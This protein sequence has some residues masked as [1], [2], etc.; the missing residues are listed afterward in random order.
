MFRKVRY[1]TVHFTGKER[2]EFADFLERMKAEQDPDH[3]QALNDLKAAIRLIGDKYGAEM[4]Y[5]RDEQD[6]TL[7]GEAMAIP[8][9]YLLRSQLRL[10]CQVL[11]PRVVILFNGDVKTKRALSAQECLK[12][13][14][15]FRK[16]NELTRVINEA[17]EEEEYL[18]WDPT[19]TMLEFSEDQVINPHEE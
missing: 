8:S 13:G 5:F 10:Y 18:R 12:V 3:Q 2:S 9:K 16:A 14:P 15:H 17:L 19:G 11:S 1:Y 7:R 6:W 4:R